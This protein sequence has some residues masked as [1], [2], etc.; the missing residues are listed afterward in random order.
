MLEEGSIGRLSCCVPWLW[1]GVKNVEF[2]ADSVDAV[3]KIDFP[4]SFSTISTNQE[5][6]FHSQLTSPT[7]DQLMVIYVNNVFFMSTYDDF[8]SIRV[9]YWSMS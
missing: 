2:V 3:I 9:I 1:S 4:C 7:S 5:T 6:E 8:T